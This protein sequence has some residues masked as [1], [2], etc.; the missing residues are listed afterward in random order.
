M[1]GNTSNDNNFFVAGN[2]TSN[3]ML[4][5]SLDEIRIFNKG[6]SSSEISYLANNS[7]ANGYA[8]QTSRIGNIFYKSG[9]S[10][11][12]DPRPKYKNALLGDTGN[13]DYSGK[14][15]GF[16]GSF[17]STTTFYEHEITCKIRKSEYNFTINPSVYKD[18]N[19]DAIQVEDYTTSSFFNPYVTTVGLYNEDRDL[20]A[21]A[22]LSSPLEKRDDVDMNVI[23]RFDV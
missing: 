14:Q 16:T 18:K 5:G 8:Y 9:I 1:I 2:G 23:I 3:G 17:R 7:F 20:V 6:L 13:Y 12:S 22:K 10:V 4:S 15:Y 21:V 11:V 19:P